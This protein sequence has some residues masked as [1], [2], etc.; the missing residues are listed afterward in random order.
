VITVGAL[1]TMGSTSRSDDLVASYSSK[2]PTL[3]D[4]IVKPDLVAPGNIISSTMTNNATLCSELPGNTVPKSAYNGSNGQSVSN[5]YFKLSGTSMAAA[6]VSGAAALLLEEDPSLTPDEIKA[7]LMKTA[8]KSFP[9]SSMATDPATGIAYTSQYDVF[10]VGA[11]SLD[12]AA[13]LGDTDSPGM[14]T[15]MSPAADYDS[16]PGNT[17][18]GLDPSSVWG[19]NAVWGTHAVW[20]TGVVAGSRRCGAPMRS[21]EPPPFRDSMRCGGP[22]Q[23]WGAG[24]YGPALLTMI[25]GE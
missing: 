20:G 3:Y 23:F 24:T 4:H 2:G 16:L 21:G 5:V 22:A 9:T 17:Y 25:N 6:M 12:I 1:K 13:A 14:A 18:L 19:N 15:A 8:S 10:T 11:G 7:R